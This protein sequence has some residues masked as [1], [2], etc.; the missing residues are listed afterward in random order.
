MRMVSNEDQAP[1][2]GKRGQQIGTRRSPT[3]Q[4]RPIGHPLPVRWP[5]LLQIKPQD[6]VAQ[7]APTTE[8]FDQGRI[9][10]S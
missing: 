6:P 1:R 5:L 10:Y 4:D 8:A 7:P 2:P 3:S 9:G